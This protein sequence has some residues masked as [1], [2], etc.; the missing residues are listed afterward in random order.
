MSQRM[1]AS[2]GWRYHK[3]G[4]PKQVLQFERFRLP[5]DRSGTQAV[6][7]MLAAPVH[8]HDKN[9]IEGAYGDVRPKNFPQVA[10]VEGLGVVEEVG[11][12]AT[13]GLKEGDFV[14]VNNQTVGTFASHIVT[15]AVNLDVMPNRADVDIEYLSS[16]S[17]FHT[18][19]HIVNSFVKTQPGD[20]VLQTGTAGAV[21]TVAASMC[22]A[23]GLKVFSTMRK[24]RSNHNQLLEERKAASCHAVLPPSY[25]RTNYMRRLLSDVPAPKLLLNNAGGPNTSHLVKLLGDGGTVVSYGSASRQPMQISNMDLIERGIKMQSF[26]LPKWVQN[27]SRE[28]RMRVHQDIVEKIS[29]DTGH[30][31]FNAQRFKMDGDSGF[32]F[33]NAWDAP[34]SSRKA[35]LR[36]VGEYGEWRKPLPEAEMYQ[37]A[38]QMYAEWDELKQEAEKTS[39]TEASLKYHAN[40]NEYCEAFLDAK[41][42]KEEGRRPTFFRHPNTPRHNTADAKV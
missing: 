29:Y 27:H 42:S 41:E 20:V 17:I 34:L 7:K 39:D 5:F 3:F 12:N 9:M 32:A 15:D 38:K 13:V 31:C 25:I 33:Q 10:G 21:T 37:G 11:S 2:Q 16:M 35:I 23:K 1:V 30:A 19:H 4:H 8:M 36:M 22:R 26:W 14:W 6:V 28:Q 40:I 24:G 18:A